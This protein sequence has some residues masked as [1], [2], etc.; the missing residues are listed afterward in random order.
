[1]RERLDVLFDKATEQRAHLPE[2]A[3]IKELREVV[4]RTAL[5]IYGSDTP[6]DVTSIT[7]RLKEQYGEIVAADIVALARGLEKEYRMNG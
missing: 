1:M 5:E 4:V 7:L 3:R 2:T 6:E